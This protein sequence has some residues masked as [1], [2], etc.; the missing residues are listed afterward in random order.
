MLL[1]SNH[2]TLKGSLQQLSRYLVANV[3]EPLIL[4]HCLAVYKTHPHTLSQGVLTTA[5]LGLVLLI[6]FL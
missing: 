1:Q 2:V 4:A 5:S 3:T 6:L